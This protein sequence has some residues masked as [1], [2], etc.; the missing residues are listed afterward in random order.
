[1]FSRRSSP[2]SSSLPCCLCWISALSSSSRSDTFLESTSSSGSG[3]GMAYSS[4]RGTSACRANGCFQFRP[5]GGKATKPLETRFKPRS[6]SWV[7]VRTHSRLRRGPPVRPLRSGLHC[8]TLPGQ[9]LCPDALQTFAVQ[10]RRKVPMW[11]PRDTSLGRPLVSKL[12]SRLM[13]LGPH[14]PDRFPEW[15]LTKEDNV[16]L[17]VRNE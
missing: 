16:P 8:K 13:F 12:D 14:Q 3:G 6:P 1:M 11:I 9:R 7:L 5:I 17:V 10:V 4:G 15:C 2:S